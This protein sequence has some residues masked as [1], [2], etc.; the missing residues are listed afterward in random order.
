M[1]EMK[2]KENG[3]R[4]RGRKV[5]NEEIQK[6]RR[7]Q[8]REGGQGKGEERGQEGENRENELS[9]RKKEKRE[10]EKK[11]GVEKRETREGEEAAQREAC[12][13]AGIPGSQD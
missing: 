10:W 4:R 12:W 3:E 5:V 11:G 8:M 1:R 13:G 2:G 6:M 9:Q 7:K